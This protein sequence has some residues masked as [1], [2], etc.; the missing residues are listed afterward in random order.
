MPQK[1]YMLCGVPGSGKSWA[2]SQLPEYSY[3]SHDAH[4]TG[5]V[6]KVVETATTSDKPVLADCPFGE[7]QLR[8]RLESK[9]LVVEPKF[10]IEHPLTIKQRDEARE[11]KPV[12][13][14]TLTRARTI[15]EK[16]DE[17]AAYRG[18]SEQVR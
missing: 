3:V 16:A 12:S 6:D 4:K 15:V 5:Y 7:R 10:I 14:A 13:K 8:E 17:W 1:V 11:K 9:G 18:T 2:A